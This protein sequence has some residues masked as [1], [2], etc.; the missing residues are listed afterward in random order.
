MLVW[1]HRLVL[2]RSIRAA[3]SHCSCEC[4]NILVVDVVPRLPTRRSNLRNCGRLP[5]RNHVDVW[6]PAARGV[7]R[8]PP[9]CR[10]GS[11][12][13]ATGMARHGSP[14][15]AN[16][17]QNAVRAIPGGQC[18]SPETREQHNPT[19]SVLPGAKAPTTL[20]SVFL[21]K[22]RQ[23]KPGGPAAE[24]QAAKGRSD[25]GRAWETQAPR[26]TSEKCGKEAP[27]TKCGPK[28]RPH[29]EGCKRRRRATAPGEGAYSPR[30][31]Q[32]ATWETYSA[33]R[34]SCSR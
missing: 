6:A 9:N 11:C 4:C 5:R 23:T 19:G 12:E 8:T 1:E 13:C 32:T 25:V 22:K 28:N 16:P 34:A 7:W 24:H 14:S 21:A 3:A 10:C 2:P 20:C 27:L 18:A 26:P 31:K 15:H 29:Q 33:P 17:P 30:P